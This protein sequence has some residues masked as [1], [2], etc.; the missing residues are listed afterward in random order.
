VEE[1]R[2]APSLLRRL[3]LPRDIAELRPAPLGDGPVAL[4]LPAHDEAGRVERVVRRLPPAVRGRPTRC[5]VV[6]DGSADGT[7]AAAAAAGAIVVRHPHQRG[8]GAAVRAGLAAALGAGAAVIAFCDA[9]GEYAPEEL[10]RVAAPILDGRADY[11]VGSRFTGTIEHMRP[12]R[13]IGNL[14]LTWALRWSARTP[15]TDGQSGYRALS[16]EAAAAAEIVH[17]YNYAQVLTLDLVGKGFRYAEVP[18]TYRFRQS[19]QSFVRLGRYLAQVLP[20]VWSELEPQSSTTWSRNEAR[21]A[22]Q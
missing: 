22:S 14:A 10:E 9:D 1:I 8:L 3:R 5:I 4:I 17:D 20:A 21:A 19:G 13:R 6:D 11:V 7:S 2:R 15:L 12:L 16:A 18:I